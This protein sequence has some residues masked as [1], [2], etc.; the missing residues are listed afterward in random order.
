MVKRIGIMLVH[1]SITDRSN[2]GA[3]AYKMCTDFEIATYSNVVRIP[4]FV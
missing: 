4:S 3:C 1:I 2:I